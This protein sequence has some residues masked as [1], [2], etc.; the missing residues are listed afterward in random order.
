[1][2]KPVTQGYVA[3]LPP[4]LPA[5]PGRKWG[6]AQNANREVRQFFTPDPVRYEEWYKKTYGLDDISD[7]CA[8]SGASSNKL[9]DDT[10]NLQS[11]AEDY[12]LTAVEE[13]LDFWDE[14][15][16]VRNLRR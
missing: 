5:D 10:R 9:L 3:Q 15:F 13:E 6:R 1:M 12:D 11:A 4:S 14:E 7:G 8:A 2:A 16:Q